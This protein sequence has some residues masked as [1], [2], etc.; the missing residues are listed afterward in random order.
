M[1][2]AFLFMESLAAQPSIRPPI[3]VV[4]GHIDHGKTTLLDYIRKS[5]VAAKESGGITQH[6]GAY[7]V[8][9]RGKKITFLDTP[10]HEA[11]SA[12]RGRGAQVADMAILVVAADE[13]IKPQTLE[14]LDLIQKSKLP[15]VIAINKID[16]PGAAPDKIKGELTEKGVLLEGWGGTIPAV[17]IS[18]VTGEGIETLLETIALLAEVESLE[19]AEVSVED[20]GVSGIIIESSLDQRRGALATLI[21]QKGTLRVGANLS[22]GITAGRIRLMENSEGGSV[23]KAPPS[24]PVRVIGFKEIPAAGEPFREHASLKEAEAAARKAKESR[25]TYEPAVLTLISGKRE[26]IISLILRAD[27]QGSLDGIVQA[28]KTLPIQRVGIEVIRAAVG[29]I[30]D[31]DIKL[32]EPQK[33][34]VVGFRVGI[35]AQARLL[36]EQRSVSQATFTLIY[37]LIEFVRKKMAEAL[38]PTLIREELG[39]LTVRAL[40]KKKPHGQIVGGTVAKGKV[41]RGASA[42]ILRN[43]QLAGRGKITQLQHE[44]TD[45]E[46]V[47]EGRDCGVSFEGD[48]ALAVGDSLMVFEEKTRTQEL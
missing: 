12:I 27:S 15:Y 16:K 8:E 24:L 31:S 2:R 38:P 29:N 19:A 22:A 23:E 25:K 4:M 42:E 14:A 35:D 5:A 36:A 7:Q 32:A 13:S 39:V 34:V 6:I 41:R 26:H 9:H 37:E 20:R 43:D 17:P 28:L 11:F 18:S 47:G 40:F 46:E 30:T 10:G 44:H 45:V 48:S 33:A 21:P 1:S 3:I